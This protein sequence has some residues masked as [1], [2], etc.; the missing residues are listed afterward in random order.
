MSLARHVRIVRDALPS[1]VR[2]ISS[3]AST[4]S[5]PQL[6]RPRAPWRTSK[7]PRHEGPTPHD[8]KLYREALKRKF[9]D[10]WQPPK[11]ISRD[12]MDGLRALHHANPDVFST[13]VL[14]QKFKISPE[15]VRRILKSKW[16][17]SKEREAE[18]LAKERQDKQSWYEDKVRHEY[19]VDPQGDRPV[20][21]PDDR[22]YFHENQRSGFE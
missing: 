10:G 11:K 14:A 12:A 16:V 6:V 21:A 19:E 20:R 8:Q 17:P 5:S 3:E 2:H 7:H 9:P 22:L 1:T 18:L 4:S 15:A 13:P